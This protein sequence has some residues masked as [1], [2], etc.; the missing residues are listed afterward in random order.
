MPSKSPSG[1]RPWPDAPSPNYQQHTIM[2]KIEISL[3]KFEEL[4]EE[5]RKRAMDDARQW[6][7]DTQ[8]EIDDDVFYGTMEAMERVLG[9][10]IKETGRGLSWSWSEDRWDDLSDDPKYLV[11]YINWVD[12]R[13]DSDKVCKAYYLPDEKWTRRHV[14][15]PKR[16]SKIIS[17]GYEDSLTDEWTDATFDRKMSHALN[18]ARAGMDIDCFVNAIVR[19]F[20]KAW[21]DDREAG[22]SD[23]NVRDILEQNS[24]TDWYLEDGRKFNL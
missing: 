11:R 7:G 18:Y 1:V 5:A 10:S 23:E 12:G 21:E 24:D 14:C 17:K 20:S 13:L 22:Y 15:Y 2:K 4:G 9:I 3:Y 6:V 16:M 8:A 19:D